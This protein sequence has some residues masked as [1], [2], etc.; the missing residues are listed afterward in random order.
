MSQ[1]S[2][3]VRTGKPRQDRHGPSSFE[4]LK[5]TVCTWRD[6]L[7]IQLRL[8][9]AGEEFQ[10]ALELPFPASHVPG[11]VISM[12]GAAATLSFAALCLAP[13]CVIEG[14]ASPNAETQRE[15]Q[16]LYRI[17]Y[18][19]RCTVQS[20]PLRP[21]P[22]L[23]FV[24]ATPNP[25]LVPSPTREGVVLL[26][27]GGLDS[28]VA[29]RKLALAG[30]PVR[31]LHV[32]GVNSDALAEEKAAQQ[33]ARRMGLRLDVVRAQ[34]SGLAKL[35]GIYAPTVFNRYPR[36]NSVPF[37][38]D[39]LLVA[40]G[41]ALALSIG[42][43]CVCLAHEYDIWRQ[44]P[45]PYMGRIVY[46]PELATEAAG[47]HLARLLRLVSG[48]RLRYASPVASW[49]KYR[50]FHTLATEM[51]ELL[52]TVSFC[53][54]GGWCGQCPKCMTYGLLAAE[55]RLGLPFINPPLE[56]LG[57]AEDAWG[58]SAKGPMVG[59]GLR[60]PLGL[61]AMVALDELLRTGRLPD[62]PT[63]DRF[64]RAHAHVVGDRAAAI[65]AR[66]LASRSVLLS[67]HLAEP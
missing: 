32:A 9:P 33:I 18:D 59:S 51:T 37:G 6:E 65:R 58:A 41:T 29:A 14:G 3:A 42:A 12:A 30:V 17:A 21:A 57:Q 28:T 5:A 24:G 49:T 25:W 8:E 26:F 36:F 39:L 1:T 10:L 7:T 16:A 61:A 53:Y 47:H 2:F 54:W 19:T 20:L 27:S 48:G 67:T 64:R 15:L 62:G 34:W 45:T 46:R 4:G 50:L 22:F 40:L 43:S 38:R 52:S 23:S 55:R 66:L 31:L 13:R 11:S 63:Y 56:A 44:Q 35:G 60:E